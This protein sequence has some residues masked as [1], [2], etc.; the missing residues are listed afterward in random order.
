MDTI[1]TTSVG[2]TGLTEIVGMSYSTGS[3]GA[4]V[5]GG[6]TPDEKYLFVINQDAQNIVQFLVNKN[7]GSLT[8]N[9]TVSAI[10]SSGTTNSNPGPTMIRT[11]PDGRFVYVTN[12]KYNQV[13]Q[14]KIGFDGKLTLIGSVST[15]SNPLDLFVSP[16]GKF[17]YVVNQGSNTVSQYSIGSNGALTSLGTVGT[18]TRPV[19]MSVSYNGK[20]AYISNLGSKDI[21]QYSIGA[22]GTL[23]PLSPA[24]ATVPLGAAPG[25]I[26]VH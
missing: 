2:A 17:A 25:A 18:G 3:N 14:Y 5:A 13:L 1:V 19:F 24:T 22:D 12:A 9:G 4:P 11:S 21:S 16:T 6:I 8:P 20:Y 15:G 23:T 7:T 26:L 10:P